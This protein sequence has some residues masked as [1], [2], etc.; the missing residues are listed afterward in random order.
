MTGLEAALQN[1]NLVVLVFPK[2]K[3]VPCIFCGF[4]EFTLMRTAGGAGV[5]PFS[6]V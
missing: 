6:V 1:G 4:F 3:Y 5:E 2:K